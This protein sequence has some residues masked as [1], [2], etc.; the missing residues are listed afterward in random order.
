[1]CAPRHTTQSNGKIE[2]F[3]RTFKHECIRPPAPVSLDDAR[4]IVSNF[5]EDYNKRR[6]HSA[7]GFITPYDKLMGREKEI[8]AARDAKLE[9]ARARRKAARE[10]FSK[11]A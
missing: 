1:M 4:R 2:R 5:I 9:A 3:N 8:F 10:E 7:I 11:A 6:L